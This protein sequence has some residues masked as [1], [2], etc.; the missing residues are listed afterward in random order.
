MRWAVYRRRGR[1][2]LRQAVGL[3]AP[4]P[5]KR[6]PRTQTPPRRVTF[7]ARPALGAASFFA[8]HQILGLTGIDSLSK[9]R[10]STSG[11]GRILRKQVFQN[12]TGEY[13]YAMAA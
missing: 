10:V 13:T 1:G 6:P 2:F 3:A 5:Q 7:A 4:A 12:T 11:V 9:L 8:H